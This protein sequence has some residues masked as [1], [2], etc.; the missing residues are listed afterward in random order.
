MGD[1]RPDN[2]GGG[3]PEDGG[4]YRR[5]L[6]GL[7]PE[8]GTI[9]VPD[10]A[11]ELDAEATAVR[12][13]LRREAMRSRW[14]ALTARGPG[15]RDREPPSVPVVIMTVA[16]ITTLL[17]LFAVTWDQ[18]RSATE[19]VGPDQARQTALPLAD[20]SLPDASGK[21]VRLADVLPALLL[22][23]EENCDCADLIRAIAAAAPP[24]VTV[25][26]VSTRATCPV[27]TEK[28]VLCLADPTGTII[29]RYP[30]TPKIST[31]PEDSSGEVA[32][33]SAGPSAGTPGTP[34]IALSRP[35]AT[36][37]AVPVDGKGVAA[38]PITVTAA[39]DVAEALTTLAASE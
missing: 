10:D 32:P 31:S 22:L 34:S 33:P 19:P 25:V 24:V 27:G 18:R 12:R 3:P 36:A 23:V 29:G 7:P 38:D 9:V 6:P 17:S 20:I 8:W 26:P 35:V 28:K 1:L 4:A 5:E 16:V 13:E 21:L 15:R 2:G 11:A 30:D 39:S 14:H 37:T